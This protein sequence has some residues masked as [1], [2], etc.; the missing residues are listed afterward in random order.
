MFTRS[1]PLISNNLWQGGMSQ[2]QSSSVAGAL[3]QCNAP[4]EHRAPVTVDYTSPNMTYI[5]ASTATYEFPTYFMNPPE[6]LPEKPQTRA[7]EELPPWEPEPFEPGP[8]IDAPP[9][10]YPEW[11]GTGSGSGSGGG[12]GRRNFARAG[13][14][15]RVPSPATVELAYAS[16]NEGSICTFKGGKISGIDYEELL[17]EL[18]DENAGVPEN[19]ISVLTSVVLTANGL[20]FK[21]R[22]LAVLE[23]GVEGDGPVIPITDCANP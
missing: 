19:T 18:R 14:Y 20:E 5:D 16:D 2:A 23:A 22:T 8:P 6:A 1:A 12:G 4:L 11:P 15:L 3:G 17:E 21:Q 9:G 10:Y 13:K 7:P